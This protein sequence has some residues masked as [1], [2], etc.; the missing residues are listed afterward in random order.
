MLSAAKRARSVEAHLCI[1]DLVTGIVGD[2]A[3]IIEDVEVRTF[4]HL[5]FI[6]ADKYEFYFLYVLHEESITPCAETTDLQLAI[7]AAPAFM[8]NTMGS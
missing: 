5:A 3:P 4:K 8:K 1:Q 2:D 6:R 7:R